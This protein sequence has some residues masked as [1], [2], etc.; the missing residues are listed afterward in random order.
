M[1]YHTVQSHGSITSRNLLTLMHDSHGVHSSTK[2]SQFV[3][4]GLLLWNE[5]RKKWIGDKKS[6]HHRQGQRFRLPK[7]RTLCLCFAK[8][9]WRCSGTITHD[10]LLK[11]NKPFSRPIPLSEVIDFVVD[12]WEQEGL[13]S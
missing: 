11:S 10:R 1:D 4:H 13:Y 6:I 3:N 12:V 2:S 7:L 9:F 5:G 8:K